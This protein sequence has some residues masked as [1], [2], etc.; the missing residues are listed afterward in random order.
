M[1]ECRGLRGGGHA[2]VPTFSRNLMNRTDFSRARISKGR[3]FVFAY[4]RW[5]SFSVLA[6]PRGRKA[7]RARAERTVALFFLFFFFFAA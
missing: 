6:G 3:L 5:C 1:D 2:G 7:L 4:R